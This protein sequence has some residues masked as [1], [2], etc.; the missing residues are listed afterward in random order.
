MRI[1][2]DFT[3]PVVM[4]PADR[5]W[6]A[7]PAG[8]VERCMLDRVSLDDGAGEVARAT[9]LVRFA[10]GSSFPSHTHGG[11][12]EYLVLDGTFSDETGDF[13]AGTYV[14]NPI[15][16]AH[17]PHTKDGCTIFVKLYQF[18]EDDA[19]QFDTALADCLA[20][21]PRIGG[22]REAP[23]HDTDGEYV[24]AVAL[25]AGAVLEH[26]GPGGAELLVLDGVLTVQDHDWP[27]GTWARQP[28]GAPLAARAGP[29]G[30]TV[31]IKTG[32]LAGAITPPGG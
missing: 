3:E 16:T 10:P 7:S 12:E 14:R 28:H 32:H 9:S 21:V 1:N 5:E 22:V 15:G 31:W 19:A 13:P 30:A 25:D 26:D 29:D 2:A 23:L 6:V 17:A 18:A 27:S 8:G 4:R 24:R 11:G 20:F